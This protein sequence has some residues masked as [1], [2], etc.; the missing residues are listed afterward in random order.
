VGKVALR[1]GVVTYRIATGDVGRELKIQ[2]DPVNVEAAALTS[3]GGSVS[4]AECV[5]RTSHTCVC[6]N[7]AP[8]FNVSV[9]V[10][11]HQVSA[12]LDI[13][14]IA[15]AGA[16]SGGVDCAMASKS[17]PIKGTDD[18]CQIVHD[19]TYCWDEAEQ[20]FHA[21][22]APERRRKKRVGHATSRRVVL[23]MTFALSYRRVKAHE[24]ALR[25][26]H[27]SA[28]GPRFEFLVDGHTQ[29]LSAQQRFLSQGTLTFFGN[30]TVLPNNQ[31]TYEFRL[32]ATAGCVHSRLLIWN[33]H[34]LVLSTP[35]DDVA[36]DA[37]LFDAT[38]F[39]SHLKH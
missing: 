29:F 31:S 11:A 4:G 13:S 15:T 37:H 9:A 25:N 34:R 21:E 26:S 3:A 18:L 22:C 27:E 2:F 10:K 1:G 23:P 33:E 6:V 38:K 7:S 14:V 35:K 32:G 5:A 8:V 24:A 28:C 17:I 19:G 12:S 20:C 30:A 36:L 39:A 16:A